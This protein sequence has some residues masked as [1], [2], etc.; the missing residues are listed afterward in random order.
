MY[1]SIYGVVL[2][3]DLPKGL[4]MIMWTLIC[5]AVTH[6]RGVAPVWVYAPF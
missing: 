4:H 5:A 3:C 6:K 2:V 1:K